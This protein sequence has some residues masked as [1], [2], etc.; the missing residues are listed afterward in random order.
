[1]GPKTGLDSLEKRKYLA[2]ATNRTT[3]HYTGSEV[4]S[5]NAPDWLVSAQSSDG[6]TAARWT[7]VCG[8]QLFLYTPYAT[9][10]ECKVI[11]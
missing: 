7:T 2:R 6:Q 8:P 4:P 9:P 3:S 11:F 5:Q 10:S 1:V